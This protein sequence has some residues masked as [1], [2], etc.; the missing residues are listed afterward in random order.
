MIKLGAFMGL[1]H[2]AY[3]KR[4]DSKNFGYAL[5]NYAAFAAF[6]LA[7][8]IT[9]P[10]LALQ[11]LGAEDLPSTAAQDAPAFD[12][13][14]G[15]STIVSIIVENDSFQGPDR[16]YTSGVKFSVTPGPLTKTTQD[17]THAWR[18]SL[19]HMIYTPNDTQ[20]RAPILNDT[21]YAAWLFLEATRIKRSQK[22]TDIYGLSAGVIGPEALGDELQN[23][24]HDVI[25]AGNV[26]GW[27]NQLETRPGIIAFAER[28]WHGLLDGEGALKWLHLSPH[29]GATAGNAFTYANAGAI[30]SIGDHDATFSLPDRLRPG[31]F[32]V[33]PTGPSKNFAW[34]IFAGGEARAV[35][36]NVF[37]DAD[38]PF[39]DNVTNNGLDRRTGVWDAQA[40]FTLSYKRA[41]LAYAHIWRSREYD[42]QTHRHIFGS[43]VLSATF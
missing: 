43:L 11:A 7:S 12:E 40:G 17:A 8:A 38:P 4:E 23:L 24:V 13:K 26:N 6:F 10:T 19:G 2:F 35:A 22:K 28:R 30:F 25:G 34:S 37:I 41:S 27:D 42:Q 39:G 15:G 21:P 16:H 36:R 20:T 31:V 18:F 1:Q 9:Q 29:L 32:G 3:P 14:A 5:K 33:G